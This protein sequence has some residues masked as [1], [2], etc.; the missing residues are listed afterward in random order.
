MSGS[1]RKVGGRHQRIVDNHVVSGDARRL[2]LLRDLTE[3]V[4]EQAIA[5]LHDIRL[6]DA[7]NFL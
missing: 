6:V 4:E 2:V 3:G 5:E 7:G 1:S